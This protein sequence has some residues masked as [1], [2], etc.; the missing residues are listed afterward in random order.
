MHSALAKKSG[1]VLGNI[2][3]AKTFS[4]DGQRNGGVAPPAAR[5]EFM[6]ERRIAGMSNLNYNSCS[7]QHHYQDAVIMEK[8][9]LDEEHSASDGG[10]FFVP[11]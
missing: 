3:F 9:A 4:V 6:H 5:G 1:Y 2:E 11:S 10:V 7:H 8:E